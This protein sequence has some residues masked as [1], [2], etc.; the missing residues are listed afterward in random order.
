MR[1]EDEEEFGWDVCRGFFFVAGTPL[2]F[3]RER[4]DLFE[5]CF[6]GGSA[7]VPVRSS[8][9]RFIALA[10]S[11]AVWRSGIAAD[12]K[13]RAPAF[14]NKFVNNVGFTR[15]FWTFA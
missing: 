7:D 12:W 8:V 4:E 3:G 9:E 2:P 6:F 10:A 1:D 15:F 14:G 11:N 5:V 13:V